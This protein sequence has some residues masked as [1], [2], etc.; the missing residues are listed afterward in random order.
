MSEIQNTFVYVTNHNNLECAELFKYLQAIKQESCGALC[1]PVASG[2][3]SR[4]SLNYAK[5]ATL[6][7]KKVL[8]EEEQNKFSQNITIRD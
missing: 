6:R 3:C 1:K 5:L 7:K 4:F 8:H 2:Y